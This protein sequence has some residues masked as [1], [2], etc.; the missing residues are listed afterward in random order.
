MGQHVHARS[1]RHMRRH[2]TG[3]TGIEDG[4]IRDEQLVI[5]GDLHL[6]DRI[7]HHGD[8]RHFGSRATGRGDGHQQG[9]FALLSP[10]LLGEIGDGF[11]R[12]DGRT[13]PQGNHQISPA[14]EETGRPPGDRRQGRVGLHGIKDRQA[15]ALA[16]Q[17]AHD[18][19]RETGFD[20]EGIGHH[21]G[22]AGRQ[23]FQR[24]KSVGAITNF[25]FAVE[26]HGCRLQ[27]GEAGSAPDLP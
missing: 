3:E 14:L 7:R 11:G 17:M 6:V 15:D 26:L 25:R 23:L 22:V 9:L 20:H 24:V 19:V 16:L 27:C 8:G 13:A 10:G 5:E 12:I 4:H 18:L 21:K 2:G 1:R